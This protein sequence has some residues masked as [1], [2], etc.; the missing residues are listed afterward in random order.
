M[1]QVI[2]SIDAHA[3]GA[4]VRLLVEGMPTPRGSSM[5][6][7]GQWMQRHA[8]HLRRSLLREPRGHEALVG[9]MLTEA[10][11]P[12]AHA[13]IVFMDGAGYP[14]LS[15]GAVLAATTI[16]LE[17]RLIDAPDP[18]RLVFDTAAGTVHA[19]A[20]VHA[21]GERRRVDSVALT[22]VPC[23]VA[24]GGHTLR[25]GTR[26]LRVDLAFGGLLYAIVDTEAVGI[27]LSGATLPELLRLASHIRDA[28][29]AIDGV[30]FTGP[31]LDPE[32]H[33]RSIVVPGGRV[34]RSPS[35][36]GTSAV[37]AVL[38]AMGL[39]DEATP[40]VHESLAGTLLRGTIARR[41]EVD[42]TPAIVP[43]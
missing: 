10:V 42:G 31:P 3:G 21:G 12:G 17:R 20:R 13:G 27:G 37:M 30:V 26:E 11:S 29:G 6:H 1:I 41:T 35:V 14:A 18:A 36:T 16:A 40:F 34:D 32:A 5:A 25:V 19:E 8:D 23:Y 24:R 39:L 4:A 33:L 9:T 15:G 43:R 28:A 7:K 2:K 22:T 38:D